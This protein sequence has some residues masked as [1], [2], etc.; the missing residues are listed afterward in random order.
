[1]G[2]DGASS[3]VVDGATV[4][5]N[6]SVDG[7]GAMVISITNSTVGGQL[8]VRTGRENSPDSVVIKATTVAQKTSIET[9]KGDDNV[10]LQNSHFNGQLIMHTG[11]GNDVV[12]ID[13]S[14]VGKMSLIATQRGDDMLQVLNSSSFSRLMI[15]A[16]GIGHDGASIAGDTTA[17]R[18]IKGS[19]KAKYFAPTT[20]AS[21]IT[22][23]TTGAIA[24]ADALRNAAIP[25][26]TLSATPAAIS[27][28]SGTTASKLKITRTGSTTAAQVV[29]L[30]SSNTSKA[31][32]PATATIPCWADLCGS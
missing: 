21:R 6:L 22:A 16:G 3:I 9:G 26:L 29:T 23:Q 2:G 20:I 24:L 1:M 7:Q 25:A 30:T 14:S 8:D 28:N 5:G 18:V 15:F 31:T 17:R 10:V 11:A 27:E 13:G 12:Y 32:V 19:Q 4:S